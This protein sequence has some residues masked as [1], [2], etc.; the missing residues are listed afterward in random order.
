M[1]FCIVCRDKPG[2]LAVRL[3]NRDA[4]LAG[5]RAL[6]PRVLVAGPLLAGDGATMTGS[7]LVIDFADRAA[8][9]DFARNDPYNRAGL[10]ENI[11]IQ[12]WRKVIPAD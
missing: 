5:L 8:A 3:A 11:D 9:D 10:F 2:S 4:H 12:A 7:L 6:G 1:Y